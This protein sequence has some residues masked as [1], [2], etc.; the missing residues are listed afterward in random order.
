MGLD[1]Y[2]YRIPKGFELTREKYFPDNSECCY[3]RKANQVR[4]WIVKHT[5]YDE[6]W[7]CVPHLLTK[8]QLLNLHIDCM[9]VLCNHDLAN[10]LLP[11]A[12]W[13]FFGGTEYGTSYLNQLQFTADM[14]AKILK[15]TN[16]KVEDIIYFEW[17]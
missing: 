15:E 16:F 14:T 4:H 6:E 9:K 13:F 3:W 1:M 12:D 5:N 7:D 11:T 17:W 10:E 2:L 8:E